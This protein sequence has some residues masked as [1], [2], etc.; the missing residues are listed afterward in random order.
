MQAIISRLASPK[1]LANFSTQVN[2][3]G[4]DV[5]GSDD[6][7]QL[8]CGDSLGACG[9]SSGASDGRQAT[10]RTDREAADG[11]IR[12][13]SRV[14]EAAIIAQGHVYWQVAC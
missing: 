1:N 14:K 11:A 13:V 5:R 3:G 8:S 2:G 12:G 7:L 4:G 6:R 10:I 9:L